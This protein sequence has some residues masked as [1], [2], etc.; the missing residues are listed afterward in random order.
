MSAACILGCA[1][2]CLSVEERALYR[3]VKP[4]GF[5][6][7]ARNIE[8]AD[9]VRRL[10]DSLREAADDADALVFVDQEG[11]R[12]QRLKPPLAR[13]RR[14]AALFGQLYDRDPDQAVEAVTLN[15]RL[16]ACE[17]AALGF[18]ADCA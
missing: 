8:D 5:I 13:L 11:G 14:P 17:L 3:D 4:W 1:G 9:Q 7:F 15:H 12:V 6:L 10:N 2:T 18:N 16:L